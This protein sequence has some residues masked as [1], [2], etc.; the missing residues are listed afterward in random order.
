MLNK[1][2]K[3]IRGRWVDEV[4]PYCFEIFRLKDTPFRCASHFSR[5]APEPDAVLDK[6]WGDK[7]P[8]GKVLPSTG[9]FTSSMLCGDCGQRSHKRLC[10]LCHQE[11]PHTF[12]EYRNYIFAVI[13]AKGAGKSH[14]IPALVEQIKHHAGPRMHMLLQPVNDNT[15]N[16]YRNDFYEP[17]Y[18]RRR[19]LVT[20]QS[21]T[22]DNRVQLPLTFSLTF[23]GHGFLDKGRIKKAVTISF[24]DTAGE[25]MKSED[26]MSIV[27]KY[28]Y[29][30]DGILLL[31]DPLQIDRVRDCLGQS[32]NLPQKETETEDIVPRVTELIR[33]G[34]KGRGLDSGEKIKIPLA[35]ALSKL[36]ALKPLMHPQMQLMASSKAG[37][38]FDKRDFDA[39][40]AEV[41]SFIMQWKSEH[42]IQQ[43]T[44]A[45]A[46][47]GFFGLSALGNPPTTTGDIPSI[48]PH[49]VADPFLWLLYKNGL[50]RSAS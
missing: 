6:A 12:G 32:A 14:Y 17:I 18:N 28:I 5:C 22:A 29:R 44:T 25:D 35:V 3:S 19:Q 46:S 21:A 49:R 26:T 36:D 23:T 33:K 16:R 20:T 7:R 38:A 8:L 45:F 10:P 13:G 39:M 30:S 43:V 4:C 37:T 27:N 24:F 11:L 42:L 9:H 1:I 15:I 50:I 47:H 48:M 34:W 41:R 31:L 2:Y 40:D